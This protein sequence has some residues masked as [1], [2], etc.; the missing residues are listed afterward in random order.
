MNWV[1][2]VLGELLPEEEDDVFAMASWDGENDRD[3]RDDVVV[4]GVVGVEMMLRVLLSSR[5]VNGR[6]AARLLEENAAKE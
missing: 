1:V 5:T 2:V 3:G 4:A 6:I